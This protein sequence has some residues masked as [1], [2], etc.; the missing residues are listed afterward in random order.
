M[1]RQFLNAANSGDMDGL[2]DLL[3]DDIELI[4]DGGGKSFSFG[5][6]KFSATRKPVL[7]P[8]NVSKF[9]LNITKK[10]NDYVPDLSMEIIYANG[11]PSLVAYSGKKA[12]C[13]LCLEITGDKV[14]NI[15][16][17]TNPDKIKT[18]YH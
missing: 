7:G 6:Q 5:K 8:E 2:I 1:L 14:S 4:A 18:V 15:Y 9:V 3:R 11:I 12:L 16:L 10:I 13:I 17:H